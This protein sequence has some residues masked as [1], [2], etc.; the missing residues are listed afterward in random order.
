MSG[1]WGYASGCLHAQWAVLGVPPFEADGEAVQQ[2][3]LIWMYVA[4]AIL[5][6]AGMS[7]FVASHFAK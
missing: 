7:I 2:G 3:A 4:V 6:I 1:K 5:I